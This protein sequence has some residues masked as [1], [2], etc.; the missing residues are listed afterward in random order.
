[1]Q[2][3]RD[4]VLPSL[5]ETMNLPGT[6]FSRG[7][8]DFIADKGSEFFGTSV[9]PSLFSA[10]QIGE[11]QG[12]QSLENAA[13]R[14]AGALSLPFQQFQQFSSAANQF[15]AQEQAP[16]SAA[17]QEFIRTDPF[18]FASLLGGLSTSTTQENL[19]FQG[20][21]NPLGGILGA[22]AGS[23]AGSGGIVDLLKSFN[24]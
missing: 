7:T 13:G 15:Q 11:G 19:A 21:Q 20:T 16:L 17:Y 2:A 18:R 8:S 1:M 14:Q 4:T 3:Y 22:F 24:N 10:L 6:F 5:R 12:F 9:A 23:Q